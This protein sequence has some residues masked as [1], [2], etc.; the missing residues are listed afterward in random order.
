MRGE[1]KLKIGDWRLKIGDWKLDIYKIVA[2]DEIIDQEIQE[3]VQHHVTASAC[4]IAKKLL[5]EQILEWNVEKIYYFSDNFRQILH[6]S[7][8]SITFAPQF[9]RKGTKNNLNYQIYGRLSSRK[10]NKYMPRNFWGS[11][12]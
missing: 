1:T 2:N 3:P 7:K 9:G 6:N 4:G 11:T 10:C 12:F 5:W 8:K